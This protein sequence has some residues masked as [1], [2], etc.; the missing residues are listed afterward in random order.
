MLVGLAYI[1][2]VKSQ[3]E[4]ALDLFIKAKRLDPGRAETYKLLG[5]VYRK[6]AQSSLAIES[7]KMFLEL[8]PNTRYKKDLQNY[9]RMMQ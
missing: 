1:N 8:S 2:F 9:I 4:I 5:D 7:Y 3:Y 6:I